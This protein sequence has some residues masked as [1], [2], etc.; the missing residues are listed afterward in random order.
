[1]PDVEINDSYADGMDHFDDVV[2]EKNTVQSK[3]SAEELKEM[4]FPKKQAMAKVLGYDV[5]WKNEDELDQMLSGETKAGGVRYSRIQAMGLSEDEVK[6]LREGNE[7]IP[8]DTFVPEEDWDDWMKIIAKSPM[9][10]NG[11]DLS[12]R[13]ADTIHILDK[14]K[15][16]VECICGAKFSVP[17]FD[18][19]RNPVTSFPC[20]GVKTTVRGVDGKPRD[21]EICMKDGRFRQYAVHEVP[22][23]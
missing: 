4:D 16:E 23:D 5:L 22:E 21:K 12:N 11:I 19:N 7:Q 17:S 3:Y 14:N 8:Q 18:N 6:K 1:M 13:N 2:A 20:P 15:K 9:A 10:F